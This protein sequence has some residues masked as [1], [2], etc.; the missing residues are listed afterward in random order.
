M[1]SST[2]SSV[3]KL[4]ASVSDLKES[5]WMLKPE[6]PGVAMSTVDVLVF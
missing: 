5:S 3:L 6:A 2:G 4:V 1:M